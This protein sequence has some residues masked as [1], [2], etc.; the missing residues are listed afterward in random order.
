MIIFSGEDF[1]PVPHNPVLAS[2][3]NKDIT[4][5]AVK[6]TEKN[7][8]KIALDLEIDLKYIGGGPTGRPFLAFTAFRHDDDPID[9]TIFLDFWIV[10]IWG[11]IHIFRDDIFQN[12]FEVSAP[13][14]PEKDSETEGMSINQLLD[15]ARS[16]GDW[17]V[18]NYDELVTIAREWPSKFTASEKAHLREALN[19]EFGQQVW[20]E[21]EEP[22]QEIKDTSTSGQ[23][24]KEALAAAKGAEGTEIM[25]P[26]ENSYGV[27]GNPPTG[28]SIEGAGKEPWT[29]G[30]VPGNPNLP[31]I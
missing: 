26:V 5:P 13:N 18:I 1:D 17:S 27:T 14:W 10:L 7:I 29:D 12:T 30:P 31:K 3:G 24:Y 4:A 20:P 25:E 11:E 8:G 19:V 2:Y 6:V 23:L 22:D 16:S 21:K 15:A 28:V 9:L